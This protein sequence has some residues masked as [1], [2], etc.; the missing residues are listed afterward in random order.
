[1]GLM[2]Y[3]I[4]KACR[5]GFVQGGLK[6]MSCEVRSWVG[7]LCVTFVRALGYFKRGIAVWCGY[8]SCSCGVCGGVG[9]SF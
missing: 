2:A 7:L 4:V 8:C 1:M 6:R 3:Q 9:V 5:V